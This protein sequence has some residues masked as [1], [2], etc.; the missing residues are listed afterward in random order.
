LSK[1]PG[2]ANSI[3]RA[4]GAYD[5]HPEGVPEE[6]TKF[7]RKASFSISFQR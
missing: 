1:N 2:S 5:Q 6:I 7:V 3:I 4:L